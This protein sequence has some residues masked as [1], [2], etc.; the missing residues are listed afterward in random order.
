M[1]RGFR[2][3]VVTDPLASRMNTGDNTPVVINEFEIAGRELRVLFLVKGGGSE[4]LTALRMF[5]PTVQSSEVKRFI[6]EHLREHGRSGCPPLF[7]GVGVGGTSEVA[8]V[9]SK[10][11]LFDCDFGFLPDVS[12]YREFAEELRC[13][14]NKLAIGV[15]G[16]GHGISVLQV[17][18]LGFPTHIATLPVAISVDCFLHRTGEVSFRF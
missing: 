14:I 13:E 5:E 11:A 6:L 12:E 1:E 3:S 9:L 2:K 16:L 15:Q 8:L 18:V 4:N 10:L 7:V 17:R